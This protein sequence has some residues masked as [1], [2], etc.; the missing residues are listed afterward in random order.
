MPKIPNDEHNDVDVFERV[1][2]R[3]LDKHDVHRVSRTIGPR[4][5]AFWSY[6]LYKWQ[7]WGILVYATIRDGL[8]VLISDDIA[9]I[10]GMDFE[11]GPDQDP[12]W[13]YIW[14]Y[15]QPERVAENPTLDDVIRLNE[16]VPQSATGY[17]KHLGEHLETFVRTMTLN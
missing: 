3:L 1:N 2:K 8:S 5:G 15:T 7:H 16:G 10:E 12:R 13:S 6:R 9:A 17:A 4:N 14:R 11:R